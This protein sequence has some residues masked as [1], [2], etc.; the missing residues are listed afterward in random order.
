MADTFLYD[1]KHSLDT[2]IA[3]TD[4]LHSLFCKNPQSDFTRDR[5]ITF[6]HYL[7]FMIQLQSKSLPNEV[8]DYFGHRVDSPAK[9]ALVQQKCK[10]L[11]EAWDYL[12]HLFINGCRL[13]HDN[14]YREYRLLACDGSDAN[15]TRN[16]SDENTFIH[17]G[18]SSY[19]AIHIN[20][21]YDITNHTY[22]DVL[23]P[24]KKKLHERKALNTM[25]DR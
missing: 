13:L 1:L 14:T 15:I 10:V 16:P 11:P 6:Q 21:L 2:Y 4:Q 20:A 5:K 19:N 22:C 9:S 8:M 12:F 25:V 7:K 3:E 17:E 18:C 24:G 23:V